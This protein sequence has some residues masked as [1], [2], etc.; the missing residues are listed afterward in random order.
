M[1]HMVSLLIQGNL[2]SEDIFEFAQSHALFCFIQDIDIPHSLAI[3]MAK[4]VERLNSSLKENSQGKVDMTTL[5]FF[6][7][8]I[9]GVR[10]I[11]KGKVFPAGS[12]LLLSALAILSKSPHESRS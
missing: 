7:L 6:F 2:N 12:S 8:V 10:Q 5:L 4:R 9:F 1:R 3:S 11:F